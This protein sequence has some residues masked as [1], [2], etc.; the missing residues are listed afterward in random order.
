MK[1]YEDGYYKKIDL[2][3]N[4]VD[5][6][7]FWGAACMSA[8]IN[9]WSIHLLCYEWIWQE[10]S[11]ARIERITG[12]KVPNSIVRGETDIQRQMENVMMKI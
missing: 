11:P 9:R 7:H 5:S 12:I 6:C 3:S 2:E 4:E 10:W 1:D 8:V